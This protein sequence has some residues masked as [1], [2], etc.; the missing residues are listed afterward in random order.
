MKLSQLILEKKEKKS[1][2]EKISQDIN[3]IDTYETI[4]EVN[5]KNGFQYMKL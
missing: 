1:Y 2:R 3:N 4:T 5:T